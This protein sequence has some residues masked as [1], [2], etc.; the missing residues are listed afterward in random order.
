MGFGVI[1]A[2]RWNLH[3]QQHGSFCSGR[4]FSNLAFCR[5][6]QLQFFNWASVPGGRVSNPLTTPSPNR[7]M[8][9]KTVFKYDVAD[10]EDICKAHSDTV[11]FQST[12]VGRFVPLNKMQ[13]L[14]SNQSL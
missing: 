3:Q 2:G 6:L 14:Q 10:E 9:P 4:A 12:S 8:Q 1:G 13:H 11:V 7:Y 5:Y